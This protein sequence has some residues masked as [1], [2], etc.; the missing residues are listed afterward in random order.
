VAIGP[1]IGPATGARSLPGWVREL[2]ADVDLDALCETVVARDLAVAF[3][4]HCEDKAFTD[5]LRASV[6]E[7][8]RTLQAVLCGHRELRD[9]R[10]EHP[11]IFGEVQAYLGIPQATLQKS[12]RVGFTVMWEAWMGELTKRAADTGI[13][14]TEALDA[15]AALIRAIL[16][17]ED[18]VA[19][20][21]AQ[22]HARTDETLNQSRAHLRQ[23]LVR[24]LLR[25][26][27]EAPAPSDL[28]MIGYE[29]ESHH[30][31]VLLPE[32]ADGAAAQVAVGLRSATGVRQSL[33]HPLG[34]SSTVIWL[35][36]TSGWTADRRA[37]LEDVITRL[38]VRASVSE[39]NRGFAGFRRSLEQ[40]QEVEQIRGAWKSGAPRLIPY[41]LV[42]LEA[43]LLKDTEAAR[44]FVRAELRSLAGNRA[45]DLRLRETLEASFRCGS[46]VS[47]AE[48]LKVH[49]HTVRNRLQK[50]EEILGPGWTDRSTEVQVAIRLHRLLPAS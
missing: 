10:F 23:R 2:S 18:H 38:G 49:E 4:E 43:L 16:E 22:A 24:D 5:R 12:Y 9:V 19:S 1:A 15:S 39:P 7:N 34:L 35:G 31:A 32:L 50:V 29:F 37:R 42:A 25:D 47:T 45:E 11:L 44:R 3:P 41:P 20:L 17:Y 21:V 46:H 14:V 26:D 40:V 48:R 13:G 33:V 6:K 28:M 27:A 8:L 36:V 30:I